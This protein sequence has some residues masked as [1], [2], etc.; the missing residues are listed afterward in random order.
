VKNEVRAGDKGRRGTPQAK[1]RWTGGGVESSDFVKQEKTLGKGG[2][3]DREP[4]LS[5]IAEEG[6]RLRPDTRFIE[7]LLKPTG[8]KDGGGRG[9][10]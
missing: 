4:S 2:V 9:G 1:D 3:K 10:S 8:R 5:R 6:R 7:I